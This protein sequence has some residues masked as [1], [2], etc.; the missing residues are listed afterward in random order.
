MSLSY[1]NNAIL[2]LFIDLSSAITMASLSTC[3]SKSKN[4][5]QAGN[6][7]VP[8]TY[9]LKFSQILRVRHCPQNAKFSFPNSRYDFKNIPWISWFYRDFLAFLKLYFH[10]MTIEYLYFE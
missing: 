6:S 1:I 4:Q 8:S 3:D 9:A 10:L 7:L 2:V 5:D